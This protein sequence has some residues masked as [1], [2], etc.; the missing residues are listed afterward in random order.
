MS[1]LSAPKDHGVC[2]C[3]CLLTRARHAVGANDVN[4][5]MVILHCVHSERGTCALCAT[6]KDAEVDEW[7]RVKSIT[8][9]RAWHNDH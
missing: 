4:G 9:L 1:A 3:V 8:Q 5:K 6:Q 2:V 7:M